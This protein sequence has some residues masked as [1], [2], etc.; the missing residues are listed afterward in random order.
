MPMQKKLAA[1]AM[2]LA[3]IVSSG[4]LSYAAPAHSHG[5]DATAITRMTLDNGRKW[6]TDQPLR[7]GMN[8]IRDTLD[9]SLP[10]IHGGSYGPDEF[11]ALAESIQ[12]YIDYIAINCKLPE[13]ADAQLHLAL[14][15]MFEGIGAL[16]GT[17][18]QE[19]GILAIVAALNAYGEHFDH[20]GWMPIAVEVH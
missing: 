6:Q 2:A 9:L 8:W 16:K 4:G 1:A 15:Q 19:R 14:E 11:S 5:G 18:A 3:V 12:E 17:T 13:E 20:P 7:D 10:L